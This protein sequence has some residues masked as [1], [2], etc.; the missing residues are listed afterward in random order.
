MAGDALT[1]SGREQREAI[2]LA[3]DR[4]DAPVVERLGADAPELFDLLTPWAR[5]VVAGAS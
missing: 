3:T 1:D 4:Q 2:E 5:T